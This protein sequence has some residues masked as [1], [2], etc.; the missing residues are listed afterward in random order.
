MTVFRP[1]LLLVLVSALVGCSQSAT[2]PQGLST[3]QSSLAA[4]RAKPLVAGLNRA[5]GFGLL[6]VMKLGER[7]GALDIVLYDALPNELPRVAGVITTVMQTPLSHV[8]L[9]AVQDHIPNVVVTDALANLK[10]TKLV[11][12]YVRLEVNAS[13]YQLASATQA[14]VEA[15]HKNARPKTGQVP[16]RDLSI[17]NVTPLKDINFTQWTAFGV[18]AANVATLR[19]FA[20]KDVL[21]PDGFGVPFWF[22]DEFMRSN[23]LYGV[24]K[25]MMAKA[26]FHSD[27]DFQDAQLLAFRKLIKAAP[28]PVA[29]SREL[30][31]V[32]AQFPATM[33][34]R[35][36]SSTNNEDLPGFSG[37][38][39]YDSKTNHPEEG[40]LDKCVKQVFS[41]VWN[42]RAFLERDYF[43]ID[44][45]ATAMGVLLIPSTSNEQAN[46]VAVSIDP[47]YKEPNAYYVNAQLGEELVTNPNALAIPEELLLYGEGTMDVVTRSSLVKPGTML[48]STQ[49]IA[50]LREA[51]GVIHARF[52]KLY[53]VQQDE[54]FAMEIEF[55]ITSRG[56]VMIKQARQWLFD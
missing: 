40:P 56:Q 48:L 51:L 34:I 41:S 32:R 22:Y 38:G 29:M 49:N 5:V 18:K 2:S 3:K 50:V 13:G 25:A 28:M 53:A 27:P 6:R 39:L 19:T 11:G 43:R 26:Q 21:V 33:S 16:Q 42:L 10:V 37:A 4:T 24:A 52:A 9:R 14:E 30:Q 15:H 35:C 36:R 31:R 44:H 17:K 12:R 20:M 46:G 47:V 7:P 54:K 1:A 23:G 8:N 45:L 55:K